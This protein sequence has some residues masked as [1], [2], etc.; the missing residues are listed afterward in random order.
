MPHAHDCE[1]LCID[2]ALSGLDEKQSDDGGIAASERHSVTVTMGPK[3]QWVLPPIN[4]PPINERSG[5]H[6]A[7]SCGV[8]CHG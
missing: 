5:Q 4:E 2:E 1:S 8:G 3:N 7:E 6:P